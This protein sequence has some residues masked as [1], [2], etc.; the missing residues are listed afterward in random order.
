MS[1]VAVLTA[2]SGD[3]ARLAHERVMLELDKDGDSPN[4]PRST[5]TP[6]Q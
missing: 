5:T 3:F 2:D 1:E 6:G 4:C